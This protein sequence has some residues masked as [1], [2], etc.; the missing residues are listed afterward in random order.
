MSQ[1]RGNVFFVCKHTLSFHL[2][3]LRHSLQGVANPLA[4]ALACDGQTEP[5]ELEYLT[6]LAAAVPTGECIVEIGSFRGRSTV[7]MALA[8]QARNVEVVAI[9]CYVAMG[10]ASAESAMLSKSI[11]FL[12]LINSSAYRN[13]QCV[14]LTAAAAAAAFRE[15]RVG[16]LFIDG[17]HSYESVRTDFEAWIGTVTRGGVIAFHDS[18][19]AHW[20]STRFVAELATR[21]TILQ[22]L[23]IVGSITAF[24]K[25][26]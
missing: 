7:A 17:D 22:K 23:K 6:Q 14:N 21:T 15:R 20:G 18:V 16:L 9:D 26:G 24:A 2:R 12:N 25:I 3:R 4:C 13:T 5:E 10:N 1:R 11:F 19:N 8:A